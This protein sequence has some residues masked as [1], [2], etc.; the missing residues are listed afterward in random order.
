MLSETQQEICR[1]I[2]ENHSTGNIAKTL[3]KSPSNITCQR[4]KIRAKL[5]LKKEEN[6]KTVLQ[7]RIQKRI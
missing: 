4:S 6:L 2:L 3:G 5:H 7:E 1:L